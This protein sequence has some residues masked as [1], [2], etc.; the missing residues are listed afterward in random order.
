MK[1]LQF[2]KY[3]GLESEPRCFTQDSLGLKSMAAHKGQSA[4]KSREETP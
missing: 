1:T 2:I 4:M 3:T